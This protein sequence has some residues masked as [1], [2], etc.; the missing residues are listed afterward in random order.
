MRGHAAVL[1]LDVVLPGQPSVG[2]VDELALQLEQPV[3]L[4]GARGVVCLGFADQHL[5]VA[6][7]VRFAYCEV[8][9]RL[10]DLKMPSLF[11]V[12]IV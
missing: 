4:E 8:K 1:L 6:L 3:S 5:P 10:E 11:E 7:D 2:V 12:K 9:N